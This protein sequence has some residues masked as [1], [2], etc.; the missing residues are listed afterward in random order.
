[1]LVRNKE[2]GLSIIIP[3]INE[4]KYI[5]KL[6][7][8]LCNQTYN[9]FEIIIV[10][11]NSKDGT[12]EV[13]G[14]YQ[15]KLK[16]KLVNVKKRNAA[17]QRN[18]GVKNS[19]NNSLIFL[20]ADN[21]FDKTFLKK[22][23]RI[24]LGTVRIF[25]I[26]GKWYDYFFFGCINILFFILQSI[27]PYSLGACIISNKEVHQKIKG[28]ND[29]LEYCEEMDYV[30]KASKIEK[31]KFDNKAKLFTSLRRF[32][33]E[34]TKKTMFKWIKAFFYNIFTNKILEVRYFGNR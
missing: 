14:Q 10:D 25:P 29:H 31:F 15:N 11:G 28:F 4:E 17:Y 30:R 2:E 5:G 19:S 18:I 21:V 7:G 6:L 8:C 1:M 24:S 27:R 13:I 16:I 26:K 9:N 12:K 22:I 33:K 34:G 20:D 3:T 23:Q 32:E